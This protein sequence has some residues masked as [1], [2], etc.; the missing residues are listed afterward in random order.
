MDF[1][2]TE[3]AEAVR[4]LAEQIFTGS[5]TVERVKEVE[6]SEDRIDRELWKELATTGLLG[7]GLPEA[8]GGAGL[9]MV[10]VCLVLEDQG[11]RVAPVPYWPTVVAAQTLAEAG[12]EQHLPAVVAGDAILTVALEPGGGLGRRRAA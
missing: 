4:D 11:R 8:H 6:A 5:V 2:F 7:I 12:H 10:E 3:E 1:S 9:G